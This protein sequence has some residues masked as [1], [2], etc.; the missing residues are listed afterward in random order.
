MKRN[1]IFLSLMSIFALSACKKASTE[2]PTTT[3]DV[4]EKNAV[5][6]AKHTWTGCGPCGDWGFN[7]FE[8]LTQ[9][10]PDEVLVAFTLGNLGGYNNTAIYD[11]M[12]NTFEIPNATPTF[13]NNLDETLSVSEAK[14]IM[15]TKGVVANANYEMK[16]ENG[17]IKLKTTTKFFQDAQGTYRLAPYLILD[18]IIAYQNGHPDGANTEHHRVAI[19]IAKPTTIAQPDFHGY[20]IAEGSIES[21]Y[22]V[23]LDC[24]VAADP[25]WDPAKISFALLIFRENE[26]GSYS[27]VNSFTK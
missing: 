24:E 26:N 16:I 25:S 14:Q 19:D 4:E 21:G 12:Q 7:T 6:I 2:A 8:S 20:R 3:L 18:G 9:N 11:F 13:H 17:S 15:E 23:N 10:N 27:L 5:L 22:T 1:L